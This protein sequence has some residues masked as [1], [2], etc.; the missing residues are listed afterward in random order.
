MKRNVIL[1]LAAGMIALLSAQQGRAAGLVPLQ[2]TI[3]PC[4]LCYDCSHVVG[5]CWWELVPIDEPVAWL[6][7]ECAGITFYQSYSYKEEEPILNITNQTSY[8]FSAKLGETYKLYIDFNDAWDWSVNISMPYQDCGHVG[9]CCY[10]FNAEWGT[11]YTSNNLD[12]VTVF[13]D[14]HYGA[15]GINVCGYFLYGLVDN[16]G[17]G[18]VEVTFAVRQEPSRLMH[19]LCNLVR[20]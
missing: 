9:S 2:V 20:P 8:L 11:D 18:T 5:P 17:K 7:V 10:V 14:S 4:T 6:D 19:F 16:Q 15:N 13:Y 1:F 3:E 12:S